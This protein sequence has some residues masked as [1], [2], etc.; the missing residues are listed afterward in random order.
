LP[1]LC[2]MRRP[3]QP[4][5]WS[6]IDRGKMS[7]NTREE[8][9]AN[10]F[11]NLRPVTQETA[12]S[13]HAARVKNFS[14]PTSKPLTEESASGYKSARYS[15]ERDD[16]LVRKE[17]RSRMAVILE[18]NLVLPHIGLPSL[19]WHRRASAS[20]Y[21]AFS[22]KNLLPPIGARNTRHRMGPPLRFLLEDWRKGAVADL[23]GLRLAAGRMGAH[24][25]PDL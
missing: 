21:A 23:F 12:G 6:L 19:P 7:P 18:E 5:N 4:N 20:S 14:R 3:S 17:F 16:G 8:G 15:S 2:V 9:L 1:T 13:S 11:K 10:L 25:Q 22:R 24:V